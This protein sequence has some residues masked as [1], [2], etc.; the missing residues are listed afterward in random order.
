[1]SIE[2]IYLFIKRQLKRIRLR[3]WPIIRV[4]S[5][6][7][8]ALVGIIW[9]EAIGQSTSQMLPRCV[10]K[11]WRLSNKL[12]KADNRFLRGTEWSLQIPMI[13]RRSVGNENAQFSTA[14]KVQ[15]QFDSPDI[16]RKQNIRNA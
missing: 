4:L 8:S 13:E 6:L 7:S 14:I 9:D 2:I 16:F 10:A 1:M 12:A 15:W 3:K 5:R 11:A